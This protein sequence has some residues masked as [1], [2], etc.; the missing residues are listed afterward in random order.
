[1]ELKDYKDLVMEMATL[2]AQAALRLQTPAFDEVTQSEAYRIVGDRRWVD[3]HIKEGTLRPIRRGTAK[4]S[5]I[6][7]S[8]LEIAALRI[9]ESNFEAKLL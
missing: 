9:A 3:R 2:G 1:M 7:Y 5:P 4:N 6:F 8:R